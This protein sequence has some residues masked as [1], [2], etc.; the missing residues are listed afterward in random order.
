MD[1]PLN[2]P[3]K[4]KNIQPSVLDVYYKY[5]QSP[6]GV[7]DPDVLMFLNSLGAHQRMDNDC[8]TTGLSSAFG[9]ITLASQASAP[10]VPQSVTMSTNNVIDESVH[11]ANLGSRPNPMESPTLSNA[12]VPLSSIH[13]FEASSAEAGGDLITRQFANALFNN[14]SFMSE[15]KAYL[16]DS[17]SLNGI[18]FGDLVLNKENAQKLFQMTWFSDAYFQAMTRLS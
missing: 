18:H 9:Q 6:A 11:T 8:S 15:L 2:D 1:T 12:G 17:D 10:S 14:S 3:I 16:T 13:E 4:W 5:S 7:V